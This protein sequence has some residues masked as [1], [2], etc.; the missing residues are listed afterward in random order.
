MK[1]V[2][3]GS[4]RD[5]LSGRLQLKDQTS[6]VQ[7]TPVNGQSLKSIARAIPIKKTPK[8]FAQT[9]PVVSKYETSTVQTTSINRKWP[10]TI[11][12][13]NPTN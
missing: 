7:S 6:I 12:R 9:I 5:H 1:Q 11:V 13:A 3:G 2:S 10:K 4:V 8:S